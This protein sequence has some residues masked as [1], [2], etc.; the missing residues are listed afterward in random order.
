MV[1]LQAA[2]MAVGG[3][4]QVLTANK[5]VDTVMTVTVSFDARLISDA[6]AADFLEAFRGFLENPDTML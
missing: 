3:G 5:A 2:I 1:S 6:D 4:R